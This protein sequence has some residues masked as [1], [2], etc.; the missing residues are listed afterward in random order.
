M[1][2]LDT[3]GQSILLLSGAGLPAWIWDDV[4]DRLGASYDTQVAPRPDNG[5]AGLR[6]YAEAAIGSVSA[7]RVTIVAHSAGGVVGAEV[8]RL[9][10]E[11]VSGFLAV[12]AVVP[13]PGGSFVTAMPVPNRWILSVA[14]RF[15]GTR[16]PDSAIRKTLAHGLDG[17][18]VDRL[19]ADFTPESQGF[20]RD[21]ISTRPWNG[22][23]G[24]ATT[25]GD[26]EL[27][28]ALQQRF[29]GRLDVSWRRELATGHLPMLEDPETL[30]EIIT[31]FVESQPGSSD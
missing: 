2:A 22:W 7:E 28:P 21:R 20:Y 15:A 1:D 29:A 30:G 17:E 3:S 12:S 5:A 16:P 6:D 9:N 27:R 31:S 10:P 23:R 13:P 24:Y 8:A 26:R 19:I 4:R 18:I 14:M 11:R 25:T